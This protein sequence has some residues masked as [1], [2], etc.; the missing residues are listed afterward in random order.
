MAPGSLH[1]G[2]RHRLVLRVDE[3]L[4]LQPGADGIEPGDRGRTRRLHV[5]PL[6]SE[7]H[8]Q[9]GQDALR[10]VELDTVLLR[11]VIGGG[12]PRRGRWRR[13]VGNEG[14]VGKD[15]GEKEA[16]AGKAVG[17]R[18]GPGQQRGRSGGNT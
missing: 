4:V 10:N 18:R 16:V 1:A 17:H 11:P 8:A 14:I 15:G 12:R 7:G 6:A 3:E 13:L 5:C 9:I 2:E